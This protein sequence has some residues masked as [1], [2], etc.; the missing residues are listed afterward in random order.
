MPEKRER[1]RLFVVHWNQPVACAATVRALCEQDVPLD[2]SVIDNNSESAAFDELRTL[3]P[4]DAALVRFA[5]NK[6][7]GPALNVMLRKWL[8]TDLSSFC[9]ISA[10]DAVLEP[11]CLKLL[12]GAMRSDT[13]IG[14]ACPQYRDATVAHLSALHGV[15]LNVETPLPRGTVQLV[16]VPHG[17]LFVVRRECLAQIGVFDE[18]YFAYGDEHELGARAIRHGWKVALVWGAIVTNPETS[19]PS[20]WRSYLFARNSLLLVRSCY[21]VSAALLRAAVILANTVRLF[22]FRDFSARARLRGV[23]DYFAGRYGRP[24]PS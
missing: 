12:L 3:L 4:R 19:T 10:H 21:G 6:G 16:D 8:E 20:A 23:H 14:L 9:V 5:E 15:K 13:R 11:D 24:L 18:R 7:W 22:F 1:T 2:V 17:T